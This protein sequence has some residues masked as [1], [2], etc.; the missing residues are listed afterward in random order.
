M[1][2]GRK[3]QIDHIDGNGLNNQKSNLRWCTYSENAM[4]AH[5]NRNGSS[6]YKGV[7]LQRKTK[8]WRCRIKINYIEI[9]GGYFRNE[10]DAAKKYDEMAI[11]YFGEF[12]KLNFKK[13]A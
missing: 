2:A 6:N 5:K 12:A 8:L 7:D 4:N 9:H 11:K 1:P 3:M 13:S 10:I